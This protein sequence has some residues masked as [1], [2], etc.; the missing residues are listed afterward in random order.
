[1]HKKTAR[2]AKHDD[3]Y[4]LDTPQRYGLISRAMHW[5][6]AYLLIWQFFSILLWKGFGP[7][8]WVKTVTSFGP[9]HGTVGLLVFLL[10][11]LRAVWAWINRTKRPPHEN[12]TIGLAARAGHIALYL[13][14]FAI[15][16][17][18]LL[19]AYGNGK[20]WNPWGLPLIPATGEERVWLIAPAN[21]LHSTLSWLL[22]ALI[23]GHIIMA[24]FHA[25]I[26]KDGIF[27]RMAG[28]LRKRSRS[29]SGRI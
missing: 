9:Y 11:I 12:G 13:L 15:P 8:E 6:M 17:L 25:I 23:A 20:G 18:A 4:W 28:P 7:A 10:V 29:V 2:Y 1:M 14:M 16:T 3:A 22:A 27:S 19:R 21:A 24:F 26:R 5:G